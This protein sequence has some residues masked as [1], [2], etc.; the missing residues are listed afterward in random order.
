VAGLASLVGV[1][2]RAN[3]TEGG[4]THQEPLVPR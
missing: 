3:D 4:S 2:G 1:T